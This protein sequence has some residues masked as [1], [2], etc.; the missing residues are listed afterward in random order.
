[1]LR[2]NPLLNWHQQAEAML[3]PYGPAPVDHPQSG[4]GGP[5]SASAAP[6][7]PAQEPIPLVAT[8]GE[9]ELEYAAIRKACMLLDQ[10]QRATLELTGPDR[11]AFL[12]RMLTQEL[13]GMRPFDVRRAFWLNRQGRIDADLRVID[14]PSRTLL[15]V[16]AFALD[17]TLA[18]LSKYVVMDDVRLRDA[19]GEHHRV[20]LH[21]PTSLALLQALCGVDVGLGADASGPPLNELEPGRAAAVQLCGQQVIIDRDDSTG[22]PGYELL[23]PTSGL[24]SVFARLVETGLDPHGSTPE[25]LRAGV[26]R[27]FGSTIKLRPG[28][29]FAYNIARV[30]AGRALYYVDFGP[31]S[32]AA[33]TGVFDDRVSL[34][35]GCYLGQE[36]VARLHA[37]GKPKQQL[38][39]LGFDVDAQASEGELDVLQPVTGAAVLATSVSKGGEGSAGG[40]QPVV[41]GAVTSSI[42]SPMRGSR[43]V[44]FAQVKFDYTRPGTKLLVEVQNGPRLRLAPEGRLEGVVL[45]SLRTLGGRG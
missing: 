1:M 6:A 9:L 12:N 16:D 8:Y 24:V 14:L 42:I 29:W 7:K 38:V 17:R 27:T 23:V 41:V 25:A 35:K 3:I 5:G 19:S 43:P 26:T 39:A 18:G 4:E 37:R 36:V 2:T 33:E 45:P 21:G 32:L 31:T 11:L 15:D 40:E 44:C 20:A 13:K 30:E 22:S 28:G 34:T 10:P